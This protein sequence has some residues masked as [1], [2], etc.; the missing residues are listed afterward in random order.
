MPVAVAVAVVIAESAV[1]WGGGD[2][3]ALFRAEAGPSAPMPLVLADRI[4][5]GHPVVWAP[6]EESRR[7]YAL[8]S[9]LI[10][11]SGVAERIGE[12]DRVALVL[13]TTGADLGAGEDAMLA[14][15]EGR[16]PA[17]PLA[18]QNSTFLFAMK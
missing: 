9:R 3:A 5:P 12:G 16:A 1:L 11:E 2:E 15:F 18:T 13:A 10:A 8:L 7:G 14:H 4:L 6:G 17:L